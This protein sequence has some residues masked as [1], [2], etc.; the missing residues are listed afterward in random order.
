MQDVHKLYANTAP[1]YI[2]DLSKHL[3]V[4][5]PM[6]SWNQSTKNNGGRPYL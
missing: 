6:G 1:F 4:L 3:W 5:A 2:R